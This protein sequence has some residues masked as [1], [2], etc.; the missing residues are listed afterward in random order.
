MRTSTLF[1]VWAISVTDT[2]AF[3]L[4]DRTQHME[5]ILITDYAALVSL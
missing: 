1:Q 5:P 2:I 4:P 3:E